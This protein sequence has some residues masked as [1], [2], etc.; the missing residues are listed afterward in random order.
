MKNYGVRDIRRE[1]DDVLSLADDECQ[2]LSERWFSEYTMMLEAKSE[3]HFG[4][5]GAVKLQLQK[6]VRSYRSYS[7]TQPLSPPGN[8]NSSLRS[9]LTSLV[10][11]G[12]PHRRARGPHR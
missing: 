4:D 7:A 3:M 10:A 12:A 2:E 5:A 1:F 9:C 11:E 6:T 8:S